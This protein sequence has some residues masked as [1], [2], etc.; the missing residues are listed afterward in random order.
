MRYS[1]RGRSLRLYSE[2]LA[3]PNAISIWGNSI[4]RWDP[5][6]EGDAIGPDEGARIIDNIRRAFEGTNQQLDVL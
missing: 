4:K 6:H 5:P 3:K 1:E 2:V